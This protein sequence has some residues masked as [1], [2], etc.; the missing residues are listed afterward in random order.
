MSFIRHTRP[1]YLKQKRA[2]FGSTFITFQS[3]EISLH[4]LL[5]SRAR[6]RFS[7]QCK[8]NQLTQFIEQIPQFI[9]QI[10]FPRLRNCIP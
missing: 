1:E 6:V 3:V 4:W 10:R 9:E 7:Q 8:N 2:T 5:S